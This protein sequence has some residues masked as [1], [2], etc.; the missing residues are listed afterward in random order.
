MNKAPK[1][2]GFFFTMPKTL[3]NRQFSCLPDFFKSFRRGTSCCGSS[4]V[5][6]IFSSFQ[7]QN[8]TCVSLQ[9]NAVKT[10][11]AFRCNTSCGGSSHVDQIFL[12]FCCS[13]SCGGALR[14]TADFALWPGFENVGENNPG[15]GANLEFVSSSFPLTPHFFEENRLY[16]RI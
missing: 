5:C 7:S 4:H 12:N 13:T 11:R 9:Y 3:M 6:Q 16:R 8:T 14:H 10:R 15:S 1:N 2:P